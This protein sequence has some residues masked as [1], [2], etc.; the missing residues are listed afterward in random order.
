MYRAPEGATPCE[1]AL[2]AFAAEAD[3]ARLLGRPSIFSFV[4]DR[5]TF[6]ANC[7][8]LG[9]EVQSCLVPRDAA[10]HREGCLATLP[11]NERLANLFVLREDSAAPAKEPPLP[12]PTP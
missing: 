12:T 1:S 4:A 8:A 11:P 6:L 3:A 2:N 10:R 7:K 5:G 9:S